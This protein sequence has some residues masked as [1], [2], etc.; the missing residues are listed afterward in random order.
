M[1]LNNFFISLAFAS[2]S[3]LRVCAQGVDTNGPATLEDS[4]VA[5]TNAITVTNDIPDS[6]EHHWQRF[7]PVFGKNMELRSSESADK[8]VVI[9]GSARIRGK[10]ESTVVVIGGDIDVDS[11]VGDSVV[12]IF[13]NVHVGTNAHIRDAIVSLPGHTEIAEGAR[14]NRQPIEFD[15]FGMG[16]GLQKWLRYCG[17]WLRPMAPQ[18]G[19][20]WVVALVF[21]LVYFLISCLFRAPVQAC[22]AMMHARPAT[23]FLIGFLTKLLLPLIIGALAVTGIGLFLAPF[24]MVALLF[25]TILGKTA[26]FEYFGGAFGRR[27]SLSWLQNSGMAFLMGIL[28]VIVLYNIPVIGLITFVLTGIW[29]LG[30]AASAAFEALRKE[31]PRKAVP[32]P[33][34]ISSEPAEPGILGAAPTIATPGGSIPPV[35]GLGGLAPVV[36]VRAGFLVRVVA[37]LLDIILIGMLSYPFRE[38]PFGLL[39]GLVYFCVFWMWRGTTIGGILLNLK[40]K[41]LDG[42]RLSFPVALVRA[43]AAAFSIFVMFLGFLWIIWDKNKQGWHDKIAGTVVVRVPAGPLI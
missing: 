40:V 36:E 37:A 34:T 4:T 1:K 8:V 24:V 15:L 42:Q 18:V 25:G 29:G 22:V 21:A 41:R 16:S 17:F 3:M 7:T 11:E 32:A 23:T 26:L 19:W 14:V 9:A 5:V 2:L 30:G 39:I 12:A 35:E 13:G 28:I 20:V 10:V 27:F 31:I 6:A 33:G 38:H 43:L